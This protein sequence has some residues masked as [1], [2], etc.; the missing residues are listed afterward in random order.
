MA[1]KGLVPGLTVF[2]Q[3]NTNLQLSMSPFSVSYRLFALLLAVSTLTH[4]GVIENADCPA[5]EDGAPPTSDI[6]L[7]PF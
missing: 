7:C 2:L 5:I 4:A 6:G 1:G 3:L